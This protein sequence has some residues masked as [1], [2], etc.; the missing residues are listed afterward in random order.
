MLIFRWKRLGM[1]YMD[2]FSVVE[3]SRRLFTIKNSTINKIFQDKSAWDQGQGEYQKIV[4]KY[5]NY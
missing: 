3:R 4:Q 1:H 5:H 2:A